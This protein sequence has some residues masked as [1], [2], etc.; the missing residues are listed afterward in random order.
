MWTR[1]GRGWRSEF[2]VLM[3]VAAFTTDEVSTRTERNKSEPNTMLES[4][5][6]NTVPTAAYTE[7][8]SMQMA[9]T[10]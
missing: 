5:N 7:D 6:Y 2:R 9:K 1:G 10:L 8:V 4:T 3:T